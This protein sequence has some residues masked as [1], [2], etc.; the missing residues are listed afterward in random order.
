MC[1]E[2][3]KQIK[4]QTGKSTDSR[5]EKEYCLQYIK[6]LS[7]FKNTNKTKNNTKQYK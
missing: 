1:Q 5:P 6:R 3:D 7:K 2:Y 4:T